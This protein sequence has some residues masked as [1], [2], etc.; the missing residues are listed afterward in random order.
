MLNE[1]VSY[2]D[3]E[4]MSIRKIGKDP[5]LNNKRKEECQ[6]RKLLPKDLLKKFNRK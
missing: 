6:L 4:F 3:M 5:L 2:S 1:I